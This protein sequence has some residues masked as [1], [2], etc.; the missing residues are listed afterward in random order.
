MLI[1]SKQMMI[2]LVILNIPQENTIDVDAQIYAGPQNTHNQFDH[3]THISQNDNQIRRWMI[4][5]RGICKDLRYSIQ[6]SK[7]YRS[8][9]AD[10]PLRSYLISMSVSISMSISECQILASSIYYS[11]P[12]TTKRR[13]QPKTKRT[14]LAPYTRPSSSFVASKTPSTPSPLSDFLTIPSLISR[15][16]IASLIMIRWRAKTN[17]SN[18]SRLLQLLASKSS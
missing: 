8:N 1:D 13:A 14:L 17:P 7:E 18:E 5:A 11:V 12:N 16:N 4:C 10:S 15:S 9:K 2:V 3:S 6:L